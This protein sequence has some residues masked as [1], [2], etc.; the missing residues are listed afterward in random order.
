MRQKLERDKPIIRRGHLDRYF[1]ILERCRI[2]L[3][4]KLKKE[5]NNMR[6]K[7]KGRKSIIMKVYVATYFQGC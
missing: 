3:K 5:R 2:I 7:W 1:E 6:P 4:K